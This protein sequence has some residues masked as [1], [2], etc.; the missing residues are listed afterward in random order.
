M[1]DN[2]EE[3]QFQR[4]RHTSE[5]ILKYL[6]GELSD[7]EQRELDTWIDESD[8]NRETFAALSNAASLN[9][10]LNEFASFDLESSRKKL[11]EKIFATAGNEISEEGSLRLKKNHS[12]VKEQIDTPLVKSLSRQ[13]I[14]MAAAALVVLCL[15]IGLVVYFQNKN[16]INSPGENT[17]HYNIK[18]SDNHT[19][20]TR[21][22]GKI[23]RLDTLNIGTVMLDG[24]AKITKTDDGEITYEA[25]KPNIN[26]VLYNSIT[27]PAGSTQR[28]VLPDGSRVWLNTQSRLEFPTAFLNKV[29][30]VSLSGEGYFDVFKDKSM[31]F[32]VKI[33]SMDLMVTGTQFNINNYKDENI[34]KST[35]IEGGV[36][37][38]KDEVSFILIPGHQLQFDRT[39]RDVKVIEKADLEAATAWRNRMFYLDNSNVPSLM[40]QIARWYDIEIEYAKGASHKGNFSGEIS[41]NISFEELLQI[42]KEGGIKTKIE[43][44]K[45]IV[46]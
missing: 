5:L 28:I 3:L 12:S 24:G 6:H 13:W 2:R 35:L 9:K 29:R 4:A 46:Y 20:L 19:Y 30:N 15:A 42:L 7:A 41:K 18:V 34:V 40:R 33:D 17:A 14:Y 43:G 38:T 25:G 11:F 10:S 8:S 39:T 23:V 21:S 1:E 37:I 27:T 26:E 45:L 32:H 16:V 31:P 22:D 36:K 44:R